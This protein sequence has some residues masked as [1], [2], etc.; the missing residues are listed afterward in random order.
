VAATQIGKRNSPCWP[1]GKAAR[2]HPY[3]ELRLE[4]QLDS[5]LHRRFSAISIS[6]KSTKM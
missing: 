2:S 3:R 5:L 6:G 4:E 1:P